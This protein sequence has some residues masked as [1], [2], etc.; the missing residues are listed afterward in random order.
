MMLHHLFWLVFFFF[1]QKL[2]SCNISVVLNNLLSCCFSSPSPPAGSFLYQARGTLKLITPCAVICCSQWDLLQTIHSFWHQSKWLFKK[3]RERERE[4]GS[5]YVRGS[6]LTST[7]YC[8]SHSSD[9][10]V[11]FVLLWLNLPSLSSFIFH[12]LPSERER[13]APVFL[14]PICRCPFA[15]AYKSL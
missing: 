4:T 6:V 9:L 13:R 1:F 15:P 10:L 14:S 11:A 8:I 12:K 2:D 3:K 7:C 5:V